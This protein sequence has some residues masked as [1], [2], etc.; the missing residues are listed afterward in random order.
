MSKKT[1]VPALVCA[2]LAGGMSLVGVPSSAQTDTAE[3]VAPRF[4]QILREDA[5]AAVDSDGHLY[6]VE[7][8]PDSRPTGAAARA[9]ARAPQFP[10]DQ[11]FLL[12]SAPG[13]QRT[14]YL[15]F[16]GQQVSGTAWNDEGLPNGTHPAWT[17]DGNAGSF[18]ARER[19]IVQEIWQRVA[20][21]FA[22]F[23]VDVTTE[24]PGTAG[25]VRSGSGDQ[26][27]GT[28]A[29][30]TP[31]NSAIQQTCDGE[32]VGIA[33]MDVFDEIG[34][35]HQPV[36]VFPQYY[37]D[38]IDEGGAK[39]IAETVSHEVGHNLNLEHDGDSKEAY[40]SGH[41]SWAPIM[42]N[43]DHE[44]ISQWSKGDY[45]GADNGQDDLAVIAN[46][47]LSR[48]TDEAGDNVAAA[49]STLPSGT[50]YITTR[51]DKDFYGIG[52][53]SGGVEITAQGAADGTNLDIDLR[54]FSSDGTQVANANPTSARVN[55]LVA[56][57]MNAT[58]ATTLEAGT[59]VVSVDGVGR[60]SWSNGYD[61]YA[62]LGAYTLEISGCD[63]GPGPDPDPVAPG[64][65]TITA[66]AGGPRGGAVTASVR[67][68]APVDDGGS[69]V[70][71]YVVKATR[72]KGGRAVYHGYVTDLGPDATS[73][74][75]N[76]R[77]KGSWSFRVQALNE[78]G[79][80][81]FSPPSRRVQAR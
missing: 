18:S 24:D 69:S 22:P 33:Y 71:G 61:D 5:S 67:W 66:V 51:A 23:D 70:T 62:S 65:P 19:T 78:V 55:A 44:P 7:P 72:W 8:I 3:P 20:E 6:Y 59:Y 27:Y 25:I 2:T 34:G 32:C 52:E 77:K 30:I 68:T 21:D 81:L 80:G 1:M 14:I 63:G 16:D 46:A 11:T 35:D 60:G 29:L 64:V 54:L 40:H 79:P 50:A 39:G 12:H 74:N 53:C 4:A 15:D 38:F 56:S 31:S 28:R 41:P 10:L 75:I 9:S 47:G 42:G 43:S 13:S 57:G 76:V 45:P 48:R 73:V 37:N 58:I 26:V 17:L 36:W 49:A